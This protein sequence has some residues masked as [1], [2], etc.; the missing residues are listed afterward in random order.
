MPNPDISPYVN[1][2]DHHCASCNINCSKRKS[3]ISHLSNYHGMTA[4]EIASDSQSQFNSNFHCQS[5]N[6]TFLKKASLHRHLSRSHHVLFSVKEIV[7]NSDIQPDIQDQNNYC[8]SCDRT[9]STKVIYNKH[10]EKLHQ[11][12][13]PN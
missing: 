1:D 9:Y 3:Y 7:F 11:I 12:Q 8:K 13:I 2:P 10:L 4:E 6:R 5:C